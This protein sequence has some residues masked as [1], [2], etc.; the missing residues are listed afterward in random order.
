MK[1]IGTYSIK[2]IV[3][4]A[5]FLILTIILYHSLGFLYVI[6]KSLLFT[7]AAVVADFVFVI[8]KKIMKRWKKSK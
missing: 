6:E 2:I 3:M 7:A 8:V 5:V 4:L 1:K